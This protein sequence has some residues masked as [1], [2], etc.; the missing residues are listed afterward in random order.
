[1]GSTVVTSLLLLLL[2]NHTSL[3]EISFFPQQGE[4]AWCICIPDLK[5]TH[6]FSPD[7]ASL[8][9]VKGADLHKVLTKGKLGY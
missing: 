4:E 7:I 9:E 1:M 8:K 2:V 5:C 6:T 3:T